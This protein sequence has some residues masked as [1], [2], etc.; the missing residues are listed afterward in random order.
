MR[1][2]RN[3]TGEVRVEV[4]LEDFQKDVERLKDR[5]TD[6][7]SASAEVQAV[8]VRGNAIDRMMKSQPSDIKGANDWDQLARQLRA[9]ARAYRSTFPLPDGAPVRR[10]NDAEAAASTASL[11]AQAEQLK[12]VVNSDNTLAKADKE[13][14]EERC[15]RGDRAGQ[16]AA[17]AVEG[18][19]AG[20]R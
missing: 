16:G 13:F 4:A 12:R 17:F 8:L 18:F 2:L 9:L 19:K 3:S 7:Y 6:D 1:S 14:R 15:R 20:D 10:I 11:I 5:Y